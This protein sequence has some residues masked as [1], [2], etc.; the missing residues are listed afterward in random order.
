MKEKV[1]TLCRRLKKCMLDDL[2]SYL[3]IKSNEIEPILLQ[4]EN[5]GC[6][7]RNEGEILY[8]GKNNVSK[9]R[10]EKKDIN[11]MFEYRTPAEKEIIIK[12]FCLE[13]PPQK[14]CELVYLQVNCICHYYAIFRKII[15]DRQFKELLK[16]YELSPQLG[17]YRKFYEKYAYFY[18]YNGK[19][20]V[21]DKLLK[22][23][24]KEKEFT[25]NEV[26]EFK[27]TYSFLTRIESHNTNEHYLYY[28]L[29]EYIWRRNK[30]YKTLYEDLINL[31]NNQQTMS[32]NE[33]TRFCSGGRYET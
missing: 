29:A 20:F 10:I 24:K 22:T 33:L 26:R 6:I 13:I 12:G 23:D 14:L 3:E 28:R 9:G 11:L 2:A 17:R 1:L 27:I 18:V 32:G 19:V 30:D 16:E 4:L 8:L 5:E 25:K 31:I 15:Y 7:K 21:S